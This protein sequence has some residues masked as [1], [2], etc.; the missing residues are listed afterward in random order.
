VFQKS[1]KKA[2]KAL[3]AVQIL[4]I[5]IQGKLEIQAEKETKDIIFTSS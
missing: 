4:R 5:D 1:A 2:K 3:R